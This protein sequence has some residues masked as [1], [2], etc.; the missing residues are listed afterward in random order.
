MKPNVVALTLQDQDKS[1][2]YKEGRV[3]GKEDNGSAE[4][5]P[6]LLTDQ[7]IMSC[8]APEKIWKKINQKASEGSS[9]NG[10]SLDS[11]ATSIKVS[12]G[13]LTNVV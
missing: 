13:K 2:G 7:D 8:L 3:H 12:S 6:N 9:S 11:T 1:N 5:G 4:D 10:F